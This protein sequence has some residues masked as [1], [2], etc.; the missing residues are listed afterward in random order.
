MVTQR[1]KQI[2]DYKQISARVFCKETGLSNGFLGKVKDVGSSKLI[3]ILSTYPEINPVWLLTGDG[4][5]LKSVD[6]QSL[7][8]SA[9]PLVNEEAIGGFGGGDNSVYSKNIRDYYVIPQLAHTKVD[10]M[11]KVLGDS[12]SP[13]Y[14]NGDTVAC[15]MIRESNFIQWNKTHLVSTKEQGLLLKKVIR[16]NDDDHLKMISINKEYPPFDVPKNEIIAMALAIGSVRVEL[17]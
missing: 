5:M 15:T 12:M 14:K 17:E 3:Q 1:I 7:S 16:G 2:I 13:K 10:F 9:I 11:I 8:K 6:E 4:E